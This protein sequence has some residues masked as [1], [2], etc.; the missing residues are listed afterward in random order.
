MKS[1]LVPVLLLIC[2]LAISQNWQPIGPEGGFFK[3]FLIDPTDSDIIYAGS[4]DGGGVWKSTDH[5]QNWSLLTSEYTNFT[6]WDLEID[7]SNNQVVYACDLYGRWGVL[8]TTNGEDFFQIVNGLSFNRDLQASDLSVDPNNPDILLLATGEDNDGDR[9]GNG[10]FKS[11]NAGNSWEATTLRGQAVPAC[12]ISSSG[13]WFA[14]TS[15]NG[16]LFSS[17]QGESWENHIDLPLNAAIY[18]IDQI[19]DH[20]LVSAGLFG[21]FLSQD[22][23][24][25][26]D[27]I[28]MIGQFNFDINLIGVDPVKAISTG[29][30]SPYLYQDGIWT[31]IDSGLL[32]N[33][34][35]IGA[36]S[37]GEEIYLGIF[38]SSEIIY[39]SNGG[40][41]WETMENNPKATEVSAILEKDGVLYASLQNSYTASG[42]ANNTSALAI[43]ENGGATWQRIEL[44]GHGLDLES[45]FSQD[46]VYLGTFAQGLFK[47]SDKFQSSENILAGNK[48]IGDFEVSSFD[49]D[50]LLVPEVD[51]SAFTAGVQNTSNGG[52]DWDESFLAVVNDIEQINEQTFLL[53]PENNGIFLSQ[54]GG[55]SWSD[56]PIALEGVNVLE[57]SVENDLIFAG[58]E[59]GELWRIDDLNSAV[60]MTVPWEGNLLKEVKN[61]LQKGDTI[62]VGLNGAER[63]STYSL[64]GGVFISQ[65]GGLS[66][67]NLSSGLT[68][69]N[70]FGM[71]GLTFDSNGNLLA[72]TYG[73]GVFKYEMSGNSLDQTN[74]QADWKVFRSKGELLVD[75]GRSYFGQ[76]DILDSNGRTILS[77]IANGNT[78]SCQPELN[79]GVY[80]AR[81]G[82]GRETMTKKFVW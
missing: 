76:V 53:A 36:E 28:G 12:L 5:G 2:Q 73:G 24:L 80:F 8:K 35:M 47:S 4:D 57:L 10:V 40:V 77:Y 26:F 13:S 1:L 70:V 78:L 43:S 33:Q 48:L 51:L 44:E 22:E 21:V 31:P 20:I 30:E 71:K 17:D 27:N 16:L 38:S 64:N 39:S 72:A 29:F 7:P 67:E 55:V 65:D 62:V 58:T 66:W 19:G 9:I 63:D 18:S 59:E 79:T 74:V 81:I 25:T 60:Q 32:Q 46:E 11:Q 15:E 82:Q 49:S 37:N 34:L 54:N 68:N 56:T 6:S 3:D 41:N 45:G 69:N 61:I 23:G 75:F 50:V 52:E 42:D 14:G